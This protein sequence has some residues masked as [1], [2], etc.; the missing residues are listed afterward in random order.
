MAL[1][2]HEATG[3]EARGAPWEQAL[4]SERSGLEGRSAEKLES[5]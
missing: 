5:D 4:A 1:A 3:S 2:D